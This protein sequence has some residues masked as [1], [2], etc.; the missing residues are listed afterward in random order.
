MHDKKIVLPGL[1]LFLALATLPFWAPSGNAGTPPESVVKPGTE[2]CVEPVEV[3]RA[4]HMQLLN[5]W[6]D[7]A[8][9]DLNREYVSSTGK[10]FNIS[11]TNTCLDCHSNKSEFCDRCHDYAGAR[12]RCWGCHITPEDH[13]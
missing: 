2:S 10:K 5:E 3:M 12:P 11:L 1:A 6:R 4:R 13:Q 8:V 7:S 9:R